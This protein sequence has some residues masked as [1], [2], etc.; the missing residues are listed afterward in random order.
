VATDG[1][2]D[3]AAFRATSHYRVFTLTR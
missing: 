3:G 2:E 1:N